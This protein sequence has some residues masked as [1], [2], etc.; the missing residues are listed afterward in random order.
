MTNKT[1]TA[2]EP[3]G[4]WTPAY[5][6]LSG[7]ESSLMTLIHESLVHNFLSKADQDRLQKALQLVK[8]VVVSVHDSQR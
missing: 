8:E 4:F 5:R 6:A 1:N 7:A 2:I 3:M